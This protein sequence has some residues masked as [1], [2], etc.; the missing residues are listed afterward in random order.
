VLRP[1][2]AGVFL[3]PA[4]ETSARVF[5]LIWRSFL[6]GGGALPRAGMRALPRQLA[7]ALPAGTV[8]TGH[9]VDRITGTEVRL[10]GGEPLRARAAV[11]ATDATAAA[12]LLPGVAEPAWHGVSTWYFA[13]PAA[14]L[15]GPVLTLDG[16]G[17][18]LVNATV[19]SEVSSAY[20]PAGR[21]LVAASV[22]GNLDEDIETPIRARLSELYG[23]D[24]REWT[25]IERYAIPRALP[26]MPAGHPLRRPVRVGD[27]SYVCG[28]HR[29]T[30]SIQGA[31]VSGRRAAD[32]VRRDLLG[33]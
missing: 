24:T 31:L 9:A 32:A 19:L 25:L 27:G 6:R 16:R 8:R 7:G 10:A 11:V 22:P 30:S 12:R 23:C 14:P 15:P 13:A 21:A 26:A 28:D 29:D 17:E 18:L 20:A 1:F 2:L 33:R 3:D 4:L 5:Q